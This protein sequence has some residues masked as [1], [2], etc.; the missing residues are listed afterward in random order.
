MAYEYK[1]PR[2][3]K[4]GKP[5]RRYKKVADTPVGKDFAKKDYSDAKTR[6]TKLRIKW[7]RFKKRLG[8]ICAV[9]AVSS[10]AYVV[11]TIGMIPVQARAEAKRDF[12]IN[13]I[14]PI[15][16]SCVADCGTQGENFNGQE[17]LR[18]ES[19]AEADLVAA[20]HSY[21]WD[22][23]HMEKILRWESSN[24]GCSLE[25]DH[26]FKGNDDGSTD[27]G[28]I[29]ANSKTYADYEARMPHKLRELGINSYQDLLDPYK[30]LDYAYYLE[31]KYKG[32]G[33]WAAHGNGAYQLCGM[34]V[35]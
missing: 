18:P 3:T 17:K 30:A 25:T 28:L 12:E 8:L 2:V 7:A 13:L 6:K 16:Y 23:S 10:M 15:R 33:A 24:Y 32:Y 5:D 29:Q 22:G 21:D 31:F 20:I 19:P 14:R 11:Y 4:S 27:M 34:Y 35:K 26:V 9:F 1:E